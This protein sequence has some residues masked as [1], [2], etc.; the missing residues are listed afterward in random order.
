LDMI[1]C[2]D[3]D[4]LPV[5]YILA[6]IK[7]CKIV[8]DSHESYMEMLDSN[9]TDIF[10]VI[11]FALENFLLRRV[12]AVVTVGE[13]LGGYFK[14][15]GAKNVEV[16]GN[17]KKLNDYLFPIGIIEN[18]RKELGI[19]NKFVI[20]YIGFLNFDRRILELIDAIKNN[21]DY[22]LL[23]GGTGTLEQEIMDRTRSSKNIIWLGYVKNSD[24]PLYVSVSDLVYF[25]QNEKSQN[26]KYSSTNKLFEALAAGKPMIASDCGENRTIIGNGKCGV[27]LNDYS[28]EHILEALGNIKEN[29]QRYSE[30]ALMLS[31]TAY[32]WSVA[33]KRL[34]SLISNV[35]AK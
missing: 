29:Y 24:I 32:N 9:V 4:T 6:K 15:R 27:L 16:V 34:I 31:T 23:V 33:E 14:E 12:D 30:N 11:I 28:K 7:R 5:G 2:H 19:E 20:V 22:F 35:L 13:I 3:F 17:W 25:A 8:Y 26:S 21:C 10:K 18:K 1:Y